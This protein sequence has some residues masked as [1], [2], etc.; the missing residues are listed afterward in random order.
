M[1]TLTAIL[2]GGGCFGWLKHRRKPK[3]VEEVPPKMQRL[4]LREANKDI[5]LAKLEI[6][7]VDTPQPKP[8]QLLIKVL[9]APVNPSDDGAW[10]LPLGNEGS[11]L[12]VATGGGVWASH[13]VG[14][15]AGGKG[16][17]KTK[18]PFTGKSYA[19]YAVV[20]A[21]GMGPWGLPSSIK[22]EDACAYFVNP[23]TVI[24]IVEAVRS[25]KGKAFIHTAAASQLGQMMVKYCQKEGIAL[26][27]LVRRKEQV[28][29]LQK[30]GAKYI[31]NTSDPEWKSMLGK[32]MMELQISQVVDCIAGDFTAE[33]I[34]LLPPGGTAWVYGRLSGKDLSSINPI[35]LIY[36]GKKLEGFLVSSWI[37]KDGMVR[38][39]LRARKQAAIVAKNFDIFGSQGF[40][41]VSMKD[42][43]QA[44]CSHLASG[45][46]GGKLRVRPW[47][48]KG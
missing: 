19:Q 5:T 28:E 16:T 25:K 9:A 15:P 27:N 35:Q 46:T 3:S 13:F 23:F 40:K 2:V 10:K 30:L 8:G 37:F 1:E 38:G 39:L 11:G 4:V 21:F 44:Y 17:P 18:S 6:E 31:V 48:F 14:Y 22:V 12:V 7:E 26:V 29:L 24:S 47:S 34:E 43:H 45:A 20:D 36:F 41:D 33:L 42:M 32:M